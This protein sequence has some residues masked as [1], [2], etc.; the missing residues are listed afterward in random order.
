MKNLV[1]VEKRSNGLNEF[2]SIQI[3]NTNN[4]GKCKFPRF[5]ETNGIASRSKFDQSLDFY[6]ACSWKDNSRQEHKNM[7]ILPKR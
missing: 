6:L 7:L 3:T 1:L 5:L 4:V 2:S